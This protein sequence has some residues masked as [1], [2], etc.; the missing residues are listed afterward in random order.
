MN[1]KRQAY[2]DIARAAIALRKIE[3]TELGSEE[4]IEVLGS[5]HKII[6]EASELF[7]GGIDELLAPDTSESL[8]SQVD[9]LA[10]F[11]TSE[12]T[13]EPSQNQGAIDTIIRVVRQQKVEIENLRRTGPV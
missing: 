9:R 5:L 3:L 13:G 6:D 11:I 4:S 2:E 8:E 1:L 7:P 12:V 10:T